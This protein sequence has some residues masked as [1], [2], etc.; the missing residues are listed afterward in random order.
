MISWQCIMAV[1]LRHYCVLKNDFFHMITDFYWP[2]FDVI[3]WGL[4]SLAFAT[5]GNV[6]NMGGI[7]ILSLSLWQPTHRANGS[8]FL[9]IIEE[10]HAQNMNNFFASPLSL[11]EYC[12]GLTIFSF[13]KA[14]LVLILCFTGGFFIFSAPIQMISASAIPLFIL[15]IFSGFVIGLFTFSILIVTGQRAAS[16]GWIAGWFFA[17]F[18]GVFCPFEALP[19]FVQQVGLWIPTS[20][21][22]RIFWAMMRG[23]TIDPVLWIKGVGLLVIYAILAIMFVQYMFKKSKQQGLARL[24]SD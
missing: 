21:F 17:P 5:Q 3:V 8:L 19:V 12:I 14:V 16:I 4:T 7:V 2:L 23:Q 13:V 18:S 10:M 9:G 1:I 15:I 11:A 22:S 20:Y 24:H 6:G